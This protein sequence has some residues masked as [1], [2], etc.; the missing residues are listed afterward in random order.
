MAKAT[1]AK[2][3]F[4]IAAGTAAFA[5]M[6]TLIDIGPSTLQSQ[7]VLGLSPAGLEEEAESSRSASEMARLLKGLV[8]E[9]GQRGAPS[10]ASDAP[11]LK[12]PSDIENKDPILK[13]LW[14]GPHEPAVSSHDPCVGVL[15]RIPVPC[16]PSGNLYTPIQLPA[17][18]GPDPAPS[19]SA[20]DV[21]SPK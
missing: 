15:G 3:R 13:G 11:P 9:P 19:S 12:I 2:A 5:V 7:R 14:P 18:G 4:F 17:P 16:G 21:S 8:V 20:P 6:C 1:M 10:P